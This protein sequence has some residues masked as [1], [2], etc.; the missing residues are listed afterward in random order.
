MVGNHSAKA[1]IFKGGSHIGKNVARP[2]MGFDDELMDEGPMFFSHAAE[3]VAFGAFDVDLEQVNTLKLVFIN[4]LGKRFERT[5]DSALFGV[6]FY[7]PVRNPTA[8]EAG[9]SCQ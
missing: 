2:R 7:E 9:Q 1:A 5:F 8:G 6:E 3:D 4:D